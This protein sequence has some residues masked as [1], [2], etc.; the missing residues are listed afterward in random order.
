MHGWDRLAPAI[1]TMHDFPRHP[2]A[3]GSAQVVRGT[4]LLARLVA[5]TFGFP[6]AGVDVPV[7][8]RFSPE[9]NA[10]RWTRT[11]GERIF[12][13]VISASGSGLRERFGPFSFR[14]RLEERN[15]TLTMVPRSWRLLGVRLP[16]GLMPD[17]VA[18]EREV[19]GI[20]HFDVPIRA[21]FVGMIVHYRGWLIPQTTH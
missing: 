8:V 11:F 4:G 18:T 2:L 14:F 17:G 19:D 16:R 9:G 15:G 7:T 5:W 6:D 13:S 1:R 12:S 3:A 20:F 21:P 10:E